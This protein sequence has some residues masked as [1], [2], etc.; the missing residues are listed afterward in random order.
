MCVETL[1]TQ[2]VTQ[3]LLSQK[4]SNDSA[5]LMAE[6]LRRFVVETFKRGKAEAESHAEDADE[7]V[8]TVEMEHIQVILPSMLFD[9]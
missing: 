9:F 2:L 7:G 8:V 5:T 6:F 3:L 4:L 1:S